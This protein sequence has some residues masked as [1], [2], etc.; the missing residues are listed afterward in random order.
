MGQGKANPSVAVHNRPGIATIFATWTSSDPQ[1]FSPGPPR[2][3][4]KGIRHE[5]GMEFTIL[6]TTI[7]LI[8]YAS[9]I[10]SADGRALGVLILSNK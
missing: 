3:T 10:S 9:S 4:A 7:Q 1:Q 2:N 6:G 8:A 5:G